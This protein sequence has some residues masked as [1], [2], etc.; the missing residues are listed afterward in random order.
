MK[1]P[2]FEIIGH[3]CRTV[4][5]CSKKLILFHSSAVLK[6]LETEFQ[7]VVIRSTILTIV[8]RPLSRATNTESGKRKF[9][10]N[11]QL[12]A[13]KLFKNSGDGNNLDDF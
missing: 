5:T 9:S 10:K 1:V 11:G 7:N 6:N 4:S 3:K 13:A 12:I 8:V 2:T